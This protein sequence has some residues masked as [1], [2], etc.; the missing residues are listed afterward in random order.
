[1]SWRVVKEFADATDHYYVY[2]AGDSF[3]RDGKVVDE[4]RI[5]ELATEANRQKVPLIKEE[6]DERK[7]DRAEKPK[8]AKAKQKE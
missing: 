6:I 8:K 5:T 1:M 7:V 4:K 3:P 2:R